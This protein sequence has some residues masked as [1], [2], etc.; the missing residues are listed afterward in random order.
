VNVIRHQ[1]GHKSAKKHVCGAVLLH[2]TQEHTVPEVYGQIWQIVS[3]VSRD[4]N[5]GKCRC[6]AARGVA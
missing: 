2:S 6:I 5:R 1:Y 4:S 3:W